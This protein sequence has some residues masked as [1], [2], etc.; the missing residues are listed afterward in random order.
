[1]KNLS[2]LNH[3]FYHLMTLHIV[4]ISIVTAYRTRRIFRITIPQLENIFHII[5]DTDQFSNN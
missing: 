4:H 2:F 5:R 3:I 1:M